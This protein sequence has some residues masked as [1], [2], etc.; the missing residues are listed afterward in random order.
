MEG[1]KA[2]TDNQR[3]DEVEVADVTC[4]GTVE[5]LGEQ[6]VRTTVEVVDGGTEWRP[7]SGIKD[8]L[9]LRLGIFG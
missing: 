6:V 2:G 4:E 8:K 3:A 9:V 7:W 1:E 5:V